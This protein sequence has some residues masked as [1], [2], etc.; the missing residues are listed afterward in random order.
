M[1]IMELMVFVLLVTD[2]VEN[3][4]ELHGMTVLLVIMDM[5]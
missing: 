2:L 4:M 5:F 1:D 3:V